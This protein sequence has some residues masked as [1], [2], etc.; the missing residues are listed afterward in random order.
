MFV[1]YNICCFERQ[2]K[3]NSRPRVAGEYPEF[4][5][6]FRLFSNR[7]MKYMSDDYYFQI[8]KNKIT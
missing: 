5:G 7:T 3:I 8:L 1:L 6:E 4:Y 2:R